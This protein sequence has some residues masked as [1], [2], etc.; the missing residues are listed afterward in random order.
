M[1]SLTLPPEVLSVLGGTTKVV[2]DKVVL[3]RI[4]FDTVKNGVN[5]DVRVTSTTSPS[6]DA[7]VG[8]LTVT[9]TKAVMEVARLSF[10]TS[11]SLSA[12]QQTALTNLVQSAQN[13]LE[14]SLI[15]LSMLDGTQTTGV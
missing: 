15:S 8:T 9:S 7:I 14:S 13:S 4:I 10:Y 12:G 2:Y 5:A 6:A 3:S 11:F 1:I